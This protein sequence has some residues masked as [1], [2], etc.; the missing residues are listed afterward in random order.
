MSGHRRQAHNRRAKAARRMVA[1]MAATMREELPFF[2]R[3]S[4]ARRSV[5]NHQMM[6]PIWLSD[7]IE[8][9]NVPF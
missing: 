6:R 2:V 1:E 5:K 7:A 4:I 3:R 9:S 8:Q